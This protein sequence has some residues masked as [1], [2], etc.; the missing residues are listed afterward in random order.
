[1]RVQLISTVNVAYTATAP[2]LLFAYITTIGV[3]LNTFEFRYIVSMTDVSYQRRIQKRVKW[4]QLL[5]FATAVL[6]AR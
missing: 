2:N 4:L 6:L 1:M 5:Q 3:Q